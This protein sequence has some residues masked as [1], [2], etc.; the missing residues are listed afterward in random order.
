MPDPVTGKPYP[1]ATNRACDECPWRRDSVPS[2]LGPLSAGDWIALAHADAP[3]AC[4]KT[5]KRTDDEGVG[6]WDDPIMRQCAGAAQFRTNVFKSPRDPEVAT[7]DDRDTT[8]VFGRND[9]FM[10]HHTS[11]EPTTPGY[12]CLECDHLE[13]GDHI[14]VDDPALACT[15]CNAEGADD[16][17]CIER[18][19]VKP[20]PMPQGFSCRDE[21]HHHGTGDHHVPVEEA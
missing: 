6:S 14:D 9:E 18:I 3:I 10:A 8:L 13:V 16:P 1:P 15:N 21:H 17:Y 5:I 2:Y 12:H 19:R 11:L 4:H 7:A 20:C